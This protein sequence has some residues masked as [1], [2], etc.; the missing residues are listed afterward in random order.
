MVICL[1][2]F[3]LILLCSFASCIIFSFFHILQDGSSKNHEYALISHEVRDVSA[4]DVKS[5][6][7][8]KME[9]YNIG[10]VI[11]QDC[12]TTS[13]GCGQAGTTADTP[14]KLQFYMIL[15][16]S[17]TLFPRQT[18]DRDRV[19]ILNRS[20]SIGQCIVLKLYTNMMD[21]FCKQTMYHGLII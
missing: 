9:A 21:F 12:P 11:L 7:P 4:T 17:E 14:L 1:L 2:Y 15:T 8:K 18:L 16:S 6:S 3:S 20:Q 19:G 10:L 5:T 13:T